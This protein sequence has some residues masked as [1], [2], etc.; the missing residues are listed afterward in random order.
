M[1]LLYRIY[2]PK[3]AGGLVAIHAGHELDFS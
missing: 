1:A 3:T 2:P